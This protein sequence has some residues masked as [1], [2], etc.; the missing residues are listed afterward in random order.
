MRLPRSTPADAGRN[1]EFSRPGLPICSWRVLNLRAMPRPRAAL[2]TKC[3][4][5][6]ATPF[7]FQ[8]RCRAGFGWRKIAPQCHPQVMHARFYLRRGSAGV[9]VPR[10]RA[11]CVAHTW[12]MR[13]LGRPRI[14]NLG[15]PRI[16]NSRRPRSRDPRYA[17][18]RN[19]GCPRCAGPFSGPPTPPASQRGC[20]ADRRGGRSAEAAL[21]GTAPAGPVR[22][23]SRPDGL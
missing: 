23:K 4:P 19:R 16:S 1:A 9:G 21:P 5:K 13:G 15:R 17:R 3:G 2:V 18:L 22:G 7:P 6:P 12:R 11:A 20:A 14:S 8:R 10:L